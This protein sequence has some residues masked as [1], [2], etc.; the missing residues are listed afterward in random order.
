MCVS[1]VT[2]MFLF[3]GEMGAKFPGQCYL[4]MLLWTTQ[5]RAIQIQANWK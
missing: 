5:P 3:L 4:S 2:D 1:Q